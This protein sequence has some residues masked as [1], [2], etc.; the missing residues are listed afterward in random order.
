MPKTTGALRAGYSDAIFPE[1]DHNLIDNAVNEK[2]QGFTIILDETSD[3]AADLC[4]MSIAIVSNR[5][6]YVMVVGTLFI[7]G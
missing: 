4:P 7:R 5:R 3:P 1:Q 2:D 6:A